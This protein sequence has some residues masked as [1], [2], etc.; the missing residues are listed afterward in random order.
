MTL[1]VS[2][3]IGWWVGCQQVEVGHQQRHNRVDVFQNRHLV[4]W[5]VDGYHTVEGLAHH[6][7]DSVSNS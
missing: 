1:W 3:G 5:A 6:N 4:S 7:E 2:F